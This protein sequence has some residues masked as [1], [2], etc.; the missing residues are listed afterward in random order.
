MSLML[1][2]RGPTFDHAHRRVEAGDRQVVGKAGQRDLGDEA[3]DLGGDDAPTAPSGEPADAVDD[4]GAGDRQ[5]VV[6]AGRDL[7]RAAAEVDGERPHP[8]RTTP[9]LAN[10][11]G[12]LAGGAE[13]EAVEDEVEGRE[14][15]PSGD[16]RRP[17]GG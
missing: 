13:V 14:R 15:R 10:A 5:R 7:D 11:G 12:D 3:D 2:N 17:G 1:R 8:G 16:E 9:G 6:N 4:L